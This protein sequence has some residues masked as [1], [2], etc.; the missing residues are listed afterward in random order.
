MMVLFSSFQIQPCTIMLH[1]IQNRYNHQLLS[2]HHYIMQLS[3]KIRFN[4]AIKPC[5]TVSNPAITPS[6]QLSIKLFKQPFKTVSI[7]H[8]F[9]PI[10][11]PPLHPFALASKNVFA[12]Q[13]ITSCHHLMHVIKYPPCNYVHSMHIS[14][15]SRLYQ[16]SCITTY[17]I[18]QSTQEIVSQSTQASFFTPILLWPRIPCNCTYFG[19]NRLLYYFSFI[20]YLK[21]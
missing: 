17:S 12:I 18:S 13:L 5:K 14:S 15:P 10:Y 9:H 16:C 1:S 7:I 20:F 3:L 21:T 19:P 6:M 8:S 11:S 2:S 4:H